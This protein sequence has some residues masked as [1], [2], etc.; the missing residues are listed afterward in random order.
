MKAPPFAYVRATSLT[1]AFHC[2]R[3]AGPEARL[4]AGGQ[5]LMPMMAFRVAQPSLLVDLRNIFQP[6]AARA[7]G[8][9][10]SS[11]GRS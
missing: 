5:S 4:L 3:D 11:I 7:A 6:A 2:W 9:D 1:D 8:L 10:Y